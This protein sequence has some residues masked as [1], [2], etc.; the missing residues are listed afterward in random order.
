MC[1]LWSGWP[2]RLWIHCEFE[3]SISDGQAWKGYVIRDLPFRAVCSYLE[4]IAS[5]GIPVHERDDR[6]ESV[7]YAL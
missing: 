5:L 2:G 7:R 3:S 1:S 6:H 4:M